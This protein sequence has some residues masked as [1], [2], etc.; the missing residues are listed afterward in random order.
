MGIKDN[1]LKRDNYSCVVCG[2]NA[3]IKRNGI[4]RNILELAHV[5]PKSENGGDLENNLISLCPN[6][7]TLF[8][9]Q[10]AFYFNI[11]TGDIILHDLNIDI[12][13][14]LKNYNRKHITKNI[15]RGNLKRRQDYSIEKHEKK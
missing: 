13:L 10:G 4:P 1:V 15:L 11:E 14:W 6:C 12:D 7:H 9:Q 2:F 3:I 5:W 8:D